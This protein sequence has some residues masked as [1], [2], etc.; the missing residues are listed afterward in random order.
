MILI[1]LISMTAKNFGWRRNQTNTKNI[2]WIHIQPFLAVAYISETIAKPCMQLIFQMEKS[3]GNTMALKAPNKES[4]TALSPQEG[5]LF[6]LQTR[7]CTVL[8]QK[9]IH[10]L[11]G[12]ISFLQTRLFLNNG[13]FGLIVNTCGG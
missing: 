13:R 6:H 10:S 4:Q 9:M 1:A 3:L 5:F 8:A 11:V 12:Q 7:S 2:S